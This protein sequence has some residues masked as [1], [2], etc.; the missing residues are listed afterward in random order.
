M[1]SGPCWQALLVANN[2]GVDPEGTVIGTRSAGDRLAGVVVIHFN[3]RGQSV[4]GLYGTEAVLTL[5][6]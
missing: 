2:L 5:L 3:L 6:A 1:R 4:R